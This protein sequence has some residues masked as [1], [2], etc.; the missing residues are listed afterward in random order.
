MR[1]S[2]QLKAAAAAQVAASDYIPLGVHVRPDVIKLKRNGDYIATWRI[3]GISFE[4]ADHDEIAIRKEGLNNFLRAL[5]G[6]HYAVWSHKVRR[7]V[8]ERLSG[9]YDSAFCRELDERYN[10]SFDT[11]RQ[12]GRAHV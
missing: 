11:H 1:A 7:Q 8:R 6:G 12:I 5:G 3:E 2:A 4:T 10:A 9:T